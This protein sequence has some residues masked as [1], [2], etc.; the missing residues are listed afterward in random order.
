MYYYTYS[1]FAI[2]SG[3]SLDRWGAK[4]TIPIGVLFL[5]IGIV[6]V[7]LRCELDGDSRPSAAGR[8]CSVRLC[9]RGI[10]GDPRFSTQLPRNRD[11]LHAVHGHARRLGRAIRGGA[12]RARTDQLAP[13]LD[14]RRR[15]VTLV[16]AVAMLVDTQRRSRRTRGRY[17]RCSRPSRR[18]DA[19]RSPTC[20]V[21]RRDLLFL[22]TT[23][24]G[25]IWGVVVPARGVARGLRRSGQP[26]LDGAARLGGR[27]SASRLHR[28]SLR[29]A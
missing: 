10:S 18:T 19:T 25:M 4:Y 21:S 22:P 5:A 8:R 13:V 26:R 16:I 24:G 6:D 29:P 7:R 9:R 15:L 3:A 2:I 28:R 17:G 20:A 11:R 12:A 1:T 23:V 27:R 14:L